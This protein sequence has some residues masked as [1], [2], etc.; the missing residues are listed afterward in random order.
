M[1]ELYV[2]VSIVNRRQADRFYN[3][4][5]EL[6][7]TLGMVTLGRGTAASD[8]L[9]YFGLAATE[10]AIFLSIVTEET[11][12]AVKNGLQTKMYIDVPG[13]GIAFTIPVS[14]IGGKKQ[15]QFLLNGQPFEKGA[16][17]TLKDTQHE[18]LVIIANQGYSELI[19]E[20]AREAKA[21]GGTVIHG[22]GT[23][24][25]AAEKFLG[26]SLASEKEAV[27]IVVPTANK[28]AV[29]QAVMEKAGLRSKAKAIALSL[30]VTST[31]GL[32]LREETED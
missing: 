29:M 22:K 32:R 27:L 7:V 16:E 23:G 28:N 26:L 1:H 30:P 13:T 4:Y 6:G 2:M 15:L 14:S 24:M 3:L 19:M 11:W 9:D 10:K 12:K 5:A 18:L 20:A 21:G 8:I 31:A 17:S 25:E